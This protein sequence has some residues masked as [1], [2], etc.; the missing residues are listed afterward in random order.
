MIRFFLYRPNG[1]YTN[2][3]EG[4]KNECYFCFETPYKS[5]LSQEYH[6]LV[7]SINGFVADEMNK[8]IF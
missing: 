5:P 2:F 1:Y 8:N 3:F 7:L 6:P 4:L